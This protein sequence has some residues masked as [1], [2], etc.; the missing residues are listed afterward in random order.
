MGHSVTPH[1]RS[2]DGW[3][4]PNSTPNGQI[5]V[6]TSEQMKKRMSRLGQIK[7]SVPINN[8]SLTQGTP[9]IITTITPT[10]GFIAT[11]LKI[12]V[13]MLDKGLVYL[14]WIQRP[15]Q[16]TEVSGADNYFNRYF[17]TGGTWE[18]TLDGEIMIGNG[19]SLKITATSDVTTNNAWCSVIYAEELE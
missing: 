1:T 6:S 2:A 9:K 14:D 7:T 12:N 13:T 16:G 8:T 15:N 3:E 18:L 5:T 10:D 4:N 19:C 11:P 17:L